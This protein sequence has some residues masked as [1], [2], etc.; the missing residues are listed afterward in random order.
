MSGSPQWALQQAIYTR[1]SG[2]ATLTSTLG[3]QVYD[4][5]PEGAAFPYVTI[6]EVT[7]GPNDTMGK[8]GR[9]ITITL[10]HWSQA[11]GMKQVHQ[12]H[13][14]VDELLDRWAPTVAGWETVEMLLEFY[15]TLRDPDGVTRH[16]VS[17]Y[18]VYVHQE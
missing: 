14:R 6:G 12:L 13:N 7:E 9:D 1:L 2:D 15:D 11:K 8:T 18:R 5:V 3:A 16:G 10:H 4:H 17:R